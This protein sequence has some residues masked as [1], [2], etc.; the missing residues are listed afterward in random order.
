VRRG[1]RDERRE[2]TLR[3]LTAGTGAR[4]AY[5]GRPLPE[6][7]PRG[8]RPTPYCAAEPERYGSWGAKV[9]TCAMLDEQREIWVHLYGP[10]Q[11]MTR[12]DVGNLDER[13]TVVQTAVRPLLDEV[14]AVQE[15]L[16][17]QM[18]A[19]IAASEE[20]AAARDEANRAMAEALAARDDALAKA[21]AALTA[22]EADRAA[23]QEADARAEQ[24][25][26]LAEAAVLAQREAEAARDEAQRER[27]QALDQVTS[28]QR[29]VADLQQ[30]L[31]SE[32]VATVDRLAHLQAERAAAEQ[33]LRTELNTECENRLAAQADAFAATERA[34]RQEA[35]V[36]IDKLT[37]DLAAATRTF[38]DELGRLHTDKA[39]LAGD[40][41]RQTAA[42]GEA[43]LRHRRLEADLVA[44]LQRAD[45]PEALRRHVAQLVEKPPPTVQG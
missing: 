34:L 3:A 1:S 18:A 22:A 6:L 13:L 42:A 17:Q 16:N 35:D 4:C 31:N 33:A 29:Q 26:T 25:R 19:T 39:A 5:C 11:P 8:G 44:A 10:D 32:R 43:E 14:A 9:I 20:A 23:R 30:T 12:L 2:A 7:S 38:A 45:D 15:Y 40:L 36:R 37:G 24:A 21:D 28:A 27:Q 41:A